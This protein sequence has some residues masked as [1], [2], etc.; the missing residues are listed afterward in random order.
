MVSNPA[1]D[2]AG[3]DG[4]AACG[5]DVGAG[6]SGVFDVVVDR[7]GSGAL[8]AEPTITIDESRGRTRSDRT[9]LPRTVA[10]LRLHRGSKPLPYQELW[11]IGLIKI[12]PIPDRC[13]AV[14]KTR[15]LSL[16]TGW[17]SRRV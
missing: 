10:P 15:E 2:G 13:G 7:A 8:W 3:G 16:I 1:L 4:R 14:R 9:H 12:K 5:R 11:G 6:A 17:Y